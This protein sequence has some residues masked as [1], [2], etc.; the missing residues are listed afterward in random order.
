MA[1][2]QS[3]RGDT[4]APNIGRAIIIDDLLEPKIARSVPDIRNGFKNL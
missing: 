4:R 3:N 2:A 1:G